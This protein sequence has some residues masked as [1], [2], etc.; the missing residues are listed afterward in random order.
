M[1][2][3]LAIK[4]KYK[5]ILRELIRK[6][7]PLIHG[8]YHYLWNPKKHSIA[9]FINHYAKNKKNVFF[10]Q[11]GSNDGLERDPLLKFIVKYHFKGIL[12]EPQYWVF[13]KLRHLHQLTKGM[14]FENAAIGAKDGKEKFYKIG[15]SESRW[16]TGLAS[17][18]KETLE[19][20]I[21]SGYV[22]ECARREKCKTPVNKEDYIKET[23]VKCVSLNTLMAKHEVKEVH[24]LQIDT[25][26]YDFEIIKMIDTKVLHPDL[27]SFEIDHLSD[28]DKQD[29]LSLLKNID[30][31]IVLCGRDALAIKEGA[32]HESLL[33]GVSF[34]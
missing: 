32:L 11:I 25:E 7:S 12:I 2:L 27:I 22:D 28:Q 17:F 23:Q 9:W 18:V 31:K 1:T 13:E 33:N 21:A 30:Y 26:G 5:N 4:Q 29:C 6:K 10:I 14:I 19:K 20:K 24:L 34:V 16:A 8:Y 15:F 3:R